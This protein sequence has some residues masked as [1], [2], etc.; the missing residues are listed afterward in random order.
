MDFDFYKRDNA[1]LRLFYWL[2]A[3]MLLVL[4]FGLGFRQLLQANEYRERERVQSHRRILLPGP[5]GDIYDREGRLLVGNRP[6]FAASVYL[7]SLR[8]EF[9]REYLL[10]V[11]EAREKGEIFTRGELAVEARRSVVQRYADKV[12]DIIGRGT[13][14]EA[15]EVERHFHQNLLLPMPLQRDLSAVEFARLTEQ[16]PVDSPVQIFT[17]SARYYP[18]GAAAA[19][20]LGFVSSSYQIPE[21]GV[22]GEELTTFTVKGQ[23]GRSGVEKS[24]DRK[25]L[26]E[27]GAEIWVVDPGGFTYERTRLEPPR[28]GGDL[29]LSLDIELQRAAE[30]AL[31]AKTGAVVALDVRTGEALVLA[32][33]PAY[34]LNDLSPFLSAKKDEEIR[35][36]GAWL[37]RA[38]Q[39]LYPPG[40]TFKLVTAIAGLHKGTI[41]PTEEVPTYPS[42]QVGG[43]R[44][45]EHNRQGF[46]PLELAGALRVSSNTYFYQKGIETGVAEIAATARLFGLD[47]PTGIELPAET[48]RMIVPDPAWKES[49]GL[50]PWFPGDTANL[51][52]GQ[53]YLLVTPLQ[54][55]AFTASFARGETR[56]K[57]SILHEPSRELRGVDHGGAPLPITS[58]Q[59]AHLV[60]G[61]EQAVQFGTARLLRTSGLRI[62]AKTGTAQIRPGGQPLTLAWTIAFAPIDNPQIAVA[63]V[64]EGQEAG[65]NYAG[66]LTAAPVVKAVLEAWQAKQ[67][68]AADNGLPLA[69]GPSAR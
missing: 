62:A 5:R 65:D 42:Y 7:N 13:Q 48:H 24:F 43:R 6:R 30:A 12:E 64:V 17:D 19:H 21:A 67:E 37:P 32:S 52:I 33:S 29:R 56:T 46:G 2:F 3:A 38:V 49:R 60:E 22:P 53:G 8:A 14:I 63:V 26:G 18:Y 16:L 4:W 45:A 34:D 15:R 25:L 27:S 28:K 58:T 9:R 69:S 55:A 68:A 36:K 54:M 61:M 41:D 39:G 31:G 44:F 66:G 23:S 47:E 51:S 59:Y 11:R 57:V 40:S 10:Q 20:T 1:R 35:E 50:G